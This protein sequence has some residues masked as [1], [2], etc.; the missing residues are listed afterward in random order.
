MSEISGKSGYYPVF[1]RLA[2]R[3]CLVVGGGAVALRKV[4][5]LLE[6]G[7]EV[8]VVAPECCADLDELARAGRIVFEGREYAA[9]EAAAFGLV[10]AAADNAEVNHGVYEDGRAAS[11]PVNV[12]DD[13][14]YCDFILPGT[15]RRGPL[16]IAVGTQGTAPFF[17]RWVRRRLDDLLPAHWGG[18]AGLAGVFRK[19]VLGRGELDAD[20]RMEL[21][22]RFLAVDWEKI[23]E[24][25]GLDGAEREM[26]RLLEGNGGGS[27]DGGP[28]N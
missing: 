6:Y 14:E 7:G 5:G 19:G 25:E 15:V 1:I 9:G 13:P 10:I 27:D 12:V 8:T 24:R 4:R 20:E 16:T 17:A 2:G 21:F 28:E 3:R 11:V 18:L 26:E 22:R 23:F